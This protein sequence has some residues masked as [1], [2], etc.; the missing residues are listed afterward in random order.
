[1][2][3][4]K[5]IAEKYKDALSRLEIASKFTFDKDLILVKGL[6][7]S[8]LGRIKEGN[9]LLLMECEIGWCEELPDLLYYY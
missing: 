6:V 8:K 9:E 7:L 5:E 2:N 3:G 1:M 4:N